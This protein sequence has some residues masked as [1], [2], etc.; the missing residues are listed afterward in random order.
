MLGAVAWVVVLFA[1]VLFTDAAAA[2]DLQGV[3]DAPPVDP[4]AAERPP[5]GSPLPMMIMFAGLIALWFYI[6]I[7]PQQKER[8]KRAALIESLKPNTEVVTI[9]G[10]HGK[11][12]KAAEG[13]ATVT[14]QVDQDTRLTVNRDAVREAVADQ[15]DAAKD[16]PAAKS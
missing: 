10:I 11:V 3:D 16:E 1:A 7:R 14:I 9:G 8:A 12:V 13:S 6:I 15:S 4:A 5:E 2:Q